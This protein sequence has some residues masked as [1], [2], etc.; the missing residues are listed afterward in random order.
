M[1]VL[2]RIHR[3]AAADPER[4]AFVF[5][6]EQIAYAHFWRLIRERGDR[7]EAFRRP[8]RFALIWVDNLFESW[9]LVLALRAM[10]YDTACVQSHEQIAL[11]DGLDVAFVVTLRS[12]PARAGGLTAG[13]DHLAVSPI[14]RP[15]IGDGEPLPTLA[16]TGPPG[17]HVLLTSGTTGHSKKVLTRLGETEASIQRM[18][19]RYGAWGERFLQPTDRSAVNLFNTG[20][21]TAGGHNWPVFAWS[22]GAAVVLEQSDQ[23]V[24]ALAH[25]GLTHT[26]ATP[27]QLS[28]L[29]ALDEDQ[30]AFRPDMQVLVL[31]GAV[32]PAL[33]HET[34]RR[35]SPRLLIGLGSTEQSLWAGSVVTCDDDLRWYSVYPDRRAQVVDETGAP[36]GP[37]KLGEVRIELAEGD[38]DG[39]L[40][41]LA[42]SAAHFAGGWFYPGDLGMFDETG[43]IALHG[44]VADVIAVQGGEKRAAQPLEQAIQARLGCEAVCLISSTWRTGAEELFVFIETRRPIAGEGVAEA[45]RAVLS[46]FPAYEFHLMTALP[47]TDSGKIKRIALAE[48]LRAGAFAVDPAWT[49]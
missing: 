32:S 27:A 17:G 38:A 31:A 45:L 23:P 12:E 19:R 24:R 34:L 43:R 9:V 33:A 46:G 42:A 18:R 26:V 48:M 28:I 10:G 29:M 11:F 40:G 21:W 22:L 7:L 6:G 8:G 4:L 35:L 2:D 37:G 39:Y 47:R 41:D 14:W 36:L 1:F 16:D 15:D 20:N 25:P 5:N 30:F 3:T 13:V 44:R 49:F